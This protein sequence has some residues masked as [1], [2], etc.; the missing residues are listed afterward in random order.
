MAK[1]NIKVYDFEKQTGSTHK[2]LGVYEIIQKARE[3]GADTL[4]VISSGNYVGEIL[5]AI[6]GQGLDSE[7]RVVNLVN[8]KAKSDLELEIEGSR[9]LRDAVERQA[10]IAERLGGKVIDFTDYIPRALERKAEEILQESQD[11]ISLGIG[12]GKLFVAIKRAIQSQGLNTKLVGVMPRGENGVFNDANLY[13]DENGDLHYRKFNPRSFADK[14]T[15][16]YTFFKDEILQ[17]RDEGH[18]LL[19]VSNSQLRQ[20]NRAAKKQGCRAELSGSAGFVI[21]NSRVKE[22][23]GISQDAEILAINSGY[24]YETRRSEL[25]SALQSLALPAAVAASALIVLGG[26]VLGRQHCRERDMWLEL[27]STAETAAGIVGGEVDFTKMS[28]SELSQYIIDS[29]KRIGGPPHYWGQTN[30][31]WESKNG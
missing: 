29:G 27:L 28:G 15:C 10:H 20:A 7:L 14:L 9:I 23:L 26:A 13:E 5:R 22:K 18:I 31:G 12:T 19:E 11:H 1:G 8:R 17:A 3:E 21:Y 25:R 30:M 16:P 24:G 2:Q 6:R 4:S